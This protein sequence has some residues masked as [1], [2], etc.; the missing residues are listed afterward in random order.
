LPT[1]IK[2]NEFKRVSRNN[3]RKKYK[4]APQDKVLIYV[5]RL[6]KEKN[7]DFLIQSLALINKQNETTKLVIVGDGPHKKELKS[8]TNKLSLSKK[9]IFTGYFKKPEVVKAYQ[10]SDLFVFASK[11]DTQ[12]MVILEAAACGLPIVAVKDAAF[13]NILKNKI[14]GFTTG[15]SKTTF[16]NKILELLNDQKQYQQMS[17]NSQELA[18]DFSIANQTDK[19]IGFYKSL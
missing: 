10:S 4:I 14:N 18:R 8:L 15:E 9:V 17:F 7:V 2:L 12:G 6:G 16:S 1:G 13:T 11:T 5:G 3:F 19:L